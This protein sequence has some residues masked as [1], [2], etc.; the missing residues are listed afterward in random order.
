MSKKAL[1]IIDAQNDFVDPAG[2]LSAPDGQSILDPIAKLMQEDT[3]QCVAMTRDWHP[4]NHVSFAKNHGVRDFSSFTYHSPVRG[5]EKDVQEATLWPVHCVQ[6]TWGAKVVGQVFQA[7]QSLKKP[8]LLVDKGFLADREYYSGFTD[9]WGEHQTE[10]Q[11]FLEQQGVT[12]VYIVG[13]VLEY[14][15]KHTA[16]D[17]SKSGFKTNILC[18]YTKTINSEEEV[19]FKVKEELR[20]RGVTLVD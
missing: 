18:K 20:Q 7:F 12:E 9:I 19:I 1:I 3:W 16:I 11:S 10:L 15:V 8:S 17:A 2:A 5:R 14:C 4:S 13:F 6:G